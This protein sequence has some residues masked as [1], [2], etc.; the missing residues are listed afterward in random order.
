MVEAPVIQTVRVDHTED[1]LA[2]VSQLFWQLDLAGQ[3]VQHQ[4]GAVKLDGFD[5]GIGQGGG[6]HGAAVHFLT[7]VADEALDDLLP[8]P[9]VFDLRQIDAVALFEFPNEAH[10]VSIINTTGG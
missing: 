5:F 2:I 6:K 9:A 7:D 10:V 4:E 8:D 3:V 1:F